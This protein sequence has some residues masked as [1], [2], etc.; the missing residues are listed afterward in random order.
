MAWKADPSSVHK[1]WDIYFRNTDAERD[2][3]EVGEGVVT[4]FSCRP[5]ASNGSMDFI[6]LNGD[7]RMAVKL[8][9][10]PQDMSSTTHA[11]M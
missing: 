9:V 1:S 8:L 5:H 6:A 4:L 11:C 7:N 3:S 2:H 10:L